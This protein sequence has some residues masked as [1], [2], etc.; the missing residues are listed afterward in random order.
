[1]KQMDAWRW[2]SM[3]WK[4]VGWKATSSFGHPF[5]PSLSVLCMAGQLGVSHKIAW[6]ACLISTGVL[7]YF[8]VGGG[9]S[10]KK[11]DKADAPFDAE[12]GMDLSSST[13]SAS[14]LAKP[15]G[16]GD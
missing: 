16:K 7:N 14:S 15:K 11:K 5:F 8:T 12:S 3:G 10:E 6:A 9:G 1:M 2:T 4:W 13:S